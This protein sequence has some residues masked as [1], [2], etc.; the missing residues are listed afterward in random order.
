ME[1]NP[2]IST[3][4]LHHS[5]NSL[6]GKFL[7]QPPSLTVDFDANNDYTISCS[8]RRTKLTSSETELRSWP[9][10]SFVVPAALYS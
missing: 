7:M 2:S 10:G 5:H 3:G 8:L 4:P 9:K 1:R 6:H